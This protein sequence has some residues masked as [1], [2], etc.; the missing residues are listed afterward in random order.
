MKWV[1]SRRAGGSVLAAA[2]VAVLAGIGARGASPL[3][4]LGGL[5]GAARGPI[6]DLPG[7]RVGERIA[8]EASLASSLLASGPEQPLSLLEWPVAP[9]VRRAVRVARHEIYAPGARMIRVDG[10]GETDV[11][12]SRLAFFWGEDDAGGRVM[13]SVDPE[14]HAIRGLSRGPDG[15]FDLGPDPADRRGRLL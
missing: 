1:S 7:A 15:F 11:P 3:R 8:F 6:V 9:G 14:T 10:N 13:V 12:R 5:R 4:A 2:A